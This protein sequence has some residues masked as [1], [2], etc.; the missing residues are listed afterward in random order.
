M[1]QLHRRVRAHITLSTLLTHLEKKKPN[2]IP[3]HPSMMS[4]RYTVDGDDHQPVVIAKL[5]EWTEDTDRGTSAGIM[6]GRNITLQRF[7]KRQRHYVH[8]YVLMCDIRLFHR[9]GH[10]NPPLLHPIVLLP[11]VILVE[12]I[13]GVVVP[14]RGQIDMVRRRVYTE[15][16]WWLVV[17]IVCL[18]STMRRLVRLKLTP[19]P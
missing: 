17:I 16:Q 11:L 4:N 6:M 9:F 5:H 18:H 3:I 10:F 2:P 1:Q 15:A 7:D 8:R 19:I 14:N 13:V 12:V